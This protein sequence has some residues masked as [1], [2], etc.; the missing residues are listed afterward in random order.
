[1]FGGKVY[2]VDDDEAVRDSARALLE[3]HLFDVEDFESGSA[4]L[5]HR[6]KNGAEGCLVLDIN[7]PELDGFAVLR[8]LGGAQPILPVVVITARVDSTTEARVRAAGASFFVEKPFTGD[9]LVEAVKSA[10]A[11]LP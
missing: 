2:V 7:M 3:S 6:G 11:G 5:E 4:F 9:Q 10:I 1:M 8:R